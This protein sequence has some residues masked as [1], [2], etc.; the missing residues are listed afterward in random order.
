MA[1][2]LSAGAG[3][4]VAGVR[5]WE[6]PAA[7][8]ADAVHEHPRTGFKRVFTEAFGQEAARVPEGRAQLLMRYGAFATAI[9]FAP[10]AE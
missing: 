2:L 9:R 8:L 5:S 1:Y 4:D 6:L 10:F 7:T 3:L